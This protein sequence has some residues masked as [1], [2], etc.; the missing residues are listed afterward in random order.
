MIRALREDELDRSFG[1][2]TAEQ[3][4]IRGVIGHMAGHFE[5]IRESLGR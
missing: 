4:I 5:A 2:W 3:Q 1:R